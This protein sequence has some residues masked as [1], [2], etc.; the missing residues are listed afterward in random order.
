MGFAATTSSMGLLANE[1]RPIAVPRAAAALATA[2]SPSGSTACTPVGEIMTGNEISCPRTVVESSRSGWMP[3][4]C[5]SKPSSPNAS[6]L[7][8]TVRPFSLAEIS[9]L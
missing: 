1:D 7:S 2:I 9:E 5:G 3:T 4:T 8:L 6:T